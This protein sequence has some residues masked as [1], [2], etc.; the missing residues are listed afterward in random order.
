MLAVPYGTMPWWC[1]LPL[2]KML[3]D[4]G[5]QEPLTVKPL[6]RVTH[7]STSSH[8]PSSSC[9]QPPPTGKT[10]CYI[11][12]TDTTEALLPSVDVH[13]VHK[14]NCT[15]IDHNRSTKWNHRSVLDYTALPS[16]ISTNQVKDSS[17]ETMIAHLYVSQYP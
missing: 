11:L 1:W 14:Q 2:Q 4:N 15:C 7:S 8:C 9:V 16:E 17:E 5:E 3:R 13:R 12:C 6:R 10:G